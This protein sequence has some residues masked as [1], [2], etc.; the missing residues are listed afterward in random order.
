MIVDLKNVVG[1]MV[2][3]L[4]IIFTLITI[5]YLKI[6]SLKIYVQNYIKCNKT[7]AH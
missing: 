6:L 7:Q 4:F 5:F 1:S 2:H 3:I